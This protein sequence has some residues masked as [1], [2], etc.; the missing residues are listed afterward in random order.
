MGGNRRPSF[1]SRGATRCSRALRKPLDS[2]AKA[3]RSTYWLDHRGLIT[4][5]GSLAETFAFIGLKRNIIAELKFEVLQSPLLKMFRPRNLNKNEEDTRKHFKLG[6]SP[7]LKRS[8]DV[9][10]VVASDGNEEEDVTTR[11]HLSTILSALGSVLDWPQPQD[12]YPHGFV[13]G[14]SR[15]ASQGVTHPGIS[16]V[17]AGL[18]SEFLWDPN[19]IFVT[20]KSGSI[21]IA[22]STLD[23]L[24][25]LLA[26]GILWFTHL[27]MKDINIYKYHNGKLRVQPVEIIIFTTIMATLGLFGSCP[28]LCCDVLNCYTPS[29]KDGSV[30]IFEMVYCTVVLSQVGMVPST[31]YFVRVLARVTDRGNLLKNM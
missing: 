16:L 31:I 14:S 19:P 2:Y 25:D 17:Q 15:P 23:S 9:D 30:S 10:F 1:E 21:A 29:N 8:K 11:S 7:L 20:V 12:I 4:K 24:L 6:Q 13:S 5:I 22:A 28:V 27:S 26:G 18:T 3:Y